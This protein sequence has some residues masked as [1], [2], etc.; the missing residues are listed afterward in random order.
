MFYQTT[1]H[2]YKR[3]AIDIEAENHRRRIGALIMSGEEQ[4]IRMN[5]CIQTEGSFTLLKSAFGLP[6]DE[7]APRSGLRWEKWLASLQIHI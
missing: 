2:D 5:R 6:M 1:K 7:P 4:R 3:L